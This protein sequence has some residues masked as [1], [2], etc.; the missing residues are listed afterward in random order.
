MIRFLCMQRYVLAVVPVSFCLRVIGATDHSSLTC[1]VH[2][3][4]FS[5]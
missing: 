5:L 3:S 2:I 1:A 4:F